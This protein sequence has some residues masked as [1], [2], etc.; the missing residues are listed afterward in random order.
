ML[1]TLLLTTLLALCSYGIF[2][3]ETTSQILGTVTDG[4]SGLPGATVTA[5][6]TPTGTRYI[7]TTR[8]D[9]RYNL[10]GL[11]IG[12]PYTIT[13][14]YVGY[15]PEKQDNVTLVVGQDFTS[16]FTLKPETTQLAAVVITG[17]TQNKIF[18]NSR[19]G[20]Q[21]IISRAQMQELPSISR[22]LADFTKLEPTS[23]GL[24]F[25]GSSASY[26]NI[27][28]DGADFNNSFGLSGTLGGQANAQPIALDAIDQ[29]Q[30]NVTP[31]DVRQGG[32]TGAGVNSV[33]RSGTNR[34]RGTIYDYIKGPGTQGYHVEN[35]VIAKTPFTFN[36]L[37]ASLGGP[38]IKDKLFFFINGEE[39]LQSAPATSVIAS[40]ASNPPVPGVVSQANSDT[41]TALA[42]FLKSQYNYDPGSFQGYSFKTNSYKVNARVDWN[43]NDQNVLSIKYNYLKSYA[44]QF[45]STSR[46]GSGQITGGQPGTYSMPYYGA[47][48]RINNNLNIYLAE[49]NTR[50]SNKASNKFQ[51]GY[52]Q[53]RDFRSPL[54]SSGTFPHVD[55]LNGGNIY[56]SFGYE[57][58][59]FNNQL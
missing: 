42:S 43:L 35:N 15:K 4:Q 29:I 53:E 30:V 34:F 11:R 24:S 28:V 59:T 55:I 49:L 3:Q 56:T 5:L 40:S 14:T 9:G 16:D 6:H 45:A 21:E 22:S 54:S 38:I 10:P 36:T 23:N 50:I 52:T 8:K 12:G 32:F 19:T 27:T 39:D 18:N 2:A 37:G 57:Q 51:V 31:Y 13:V 1:K 46:P 48:Y 44:D 7:T 25:S 26:N 58:Y 20:S 33:T 47:G 41:L 17:T